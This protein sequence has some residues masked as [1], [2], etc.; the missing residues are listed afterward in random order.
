LIGLGTLINILAISIGATIGVLVG[1][2]I[3]Q[4]ARDIVTDALGLV[5]LLIGAFSAVAI[6]D[7]NLTQ[8]LPSGVP[9][10]I[11]LAALVTGGLIGNYLQLENRIENLGEKLKQRFANEGESS[12]K[13]VE[14]FV[15][16]SLVFA[17]GPLAILGAISDGL[18]RGIDQLVLKSTLDFF[19]S[20]AFA[21]SLGWGV[22]FSA[23]V[24]GIYQGVFTVIGF[25]LGEVLSLAAIALLNAVGGLL[26]IGVGIRLLRL[27]QIPVGDLLPALLLAPIF[28]SLATVWL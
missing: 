15:S 27:R 9:V 24:V 12:K 4:S 8:S 7:P 2:R 3:A 10:L 26:L 18:G 23:I 22:A 6:A 13:F 20:I 11:L 5:T 14:G 21:A 17:V 28:L 25:F 19:A 1:N 16:A